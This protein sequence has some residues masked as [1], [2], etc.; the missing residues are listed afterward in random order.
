MARSG[1]SLGLESSI[2][3]AANDAGMKGLS[4]PDWDHKRCSDPV[5]GAFVGSWPRVS[6]VERGV[7]ADCEASSAVLC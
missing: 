4:Q 5:R 1:D 7:T 3:R 2:A 6:F